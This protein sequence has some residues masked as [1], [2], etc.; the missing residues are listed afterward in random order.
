MAWLLGTEVCKHALSVP[1][2]FPYSRQQSGDN[3]DFLFHLGFPTNYC[4]ELLRLEQIE[5]YMRI[6]LLDLSNHFEHK[7]PQL[8]DQNQ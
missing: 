1:C 4:V 8:I 7:D 2:Q 3:T 6:L 5:W